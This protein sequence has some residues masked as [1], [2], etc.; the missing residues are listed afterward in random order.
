MQGL[1]N[2]IKD[3]GLYFKPDWRPLSVLHGAKGGV[4]WHDQVCVLEDCSGCQVENE[5]EG[6]E[7]L[8]NNLSESEW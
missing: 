4:E 5:L 3:S 7:C 6:Q 2:H 1:V 8:H